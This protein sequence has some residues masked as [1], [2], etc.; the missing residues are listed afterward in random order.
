MS[1]LLQTVF[2]FAQAGLYQFTTSTTGEAV[3]GERF[4]LT[5][6][7]EAE[8][9]S[10]EELPSFPGMKVVAANAEDIEE[11]IRDGYYVQRLVIHFDVI[12][13]DCG[14]LEVPRMQAEINRNTE[15]S[16]PLTLDVRPN[17]GYGKEWVTARDF[18][19]SKGADP[20]KMQLRLKYSL[21][22]LHIFSD[23]RNGSFA[24]VASDENGP[25]MENPVLAYSTE[26][27]FIGVETNDGGNVLNEI[28]HYYNRIL[29]GEEGNGDGMNG[30]SQESLRLRADYII[31]RNYSPRLKCLWN[32]DP[33]I[34]QKEL[35]ENREA[36]VR[37][38]DYY[39][40]CDGFKDGFFHYDFNSEDICN[41]YYRNP[42]PFQEVLIG[43][44]R[45]D[46]GMHLEREVTLEAAGTLESILGD[47]AQLI[48]NLKVNGP[49]NGND[50]RLLRRMAG[51][52]DAENPEFSGMLMGLNLSDAMIVSEG[53]KYYSCYAGNMRFSG[54][55]AAGNDF[56]FL[57]S[58]ATD[59]DWE[60]MRES[61]MDRNEKFGFI[62]SKENGES[63]VGFFTV[64]DSVGPYMFA[65]CVNLRE[66]ALPWRTF[67]IGEYAFADCPCL[68]QVYI[69]ND[70][71]SIGNR[72][73]Y[74]NY[75]LEAVSVPGK[76]T[77]GNY[78][79]ELF[80]NTGANCRQFVRRNK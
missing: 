37:Q 53:H 33:G 39:F 36:I 35:E 9:F 69:L 17:P 22:S 56:D 79:K 67:Y 19:V 30:S 4:R 14:K 55:T 59:Q 74:N 15:Y 12:P 23:H 45:M 38:G 34:L 73:F 62:L 71:E 77:V 3:Q 46:E 10:V 78:G 20:A 11:V 41:G 57:L 61:G 42:G 24:V 1:A 76:F 31:D 18:L 58:T 50:I 6:T 16:T 63:S 27:P 68:Q 29:S 40:T 5:Y 32:A 64:E 49:V 43:M 65:G 72:A 70:L 13:Y 66:I 48:T 25:A 28:I 8:E 52:D 54:T 80:Y 60:I 75:K 7:L 47:E 26:T 2:C 51:A 44:V 21:N